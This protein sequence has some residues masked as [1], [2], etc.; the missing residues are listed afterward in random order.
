MSN[1]DILSTYFQQNIEIFVG[2]LKER[3]GLEDTGINGKIILKQDN[4][5]SWLGTIWLRI[6]T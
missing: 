6:G 4:R 2:S 3:G 5:R 1:I